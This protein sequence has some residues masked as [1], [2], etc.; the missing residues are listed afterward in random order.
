MNDLSISAKDV[1]MNRKATPTSS[2][3][4]ALRCLLCK[5]ESNR[6]VGTDEAFKLRRCALCG[7]TFHRDFTT[8]SE[9]R[10]YYDHYY[11]DENLAFSAITEARFRELI[12]SF[13]RYRESNRILDVGC[14]SGH[15]LKVAKDNEWRT[16]GTEIASGAMDQ[17]SSLGITGFCGELQAAAYAAEFFDVIYCSE[18]IEHVL[19]PF[20]LLGEIARVLRRDGMLYLTTPNY[21]SLSRR[22]LG[23]KWRNIALEHISYFTPRTISRALGEAGFRKIGASTRNIDPYELKKVFIRSHRDSGSGFQI[24]RTDNFREHLESNRTLRA[25]KNLANVLLRATAMGDTIVVRAEK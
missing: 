16:Y 10:E 25:A 24:A 2:N 11:H 18:V 12:T 5:S 22:L 14:G 13:E 21:D 4:E 19:D 23:F 20:A 6:L 17:L 8:D 7:F 15:F 3:G 1:T 9:V